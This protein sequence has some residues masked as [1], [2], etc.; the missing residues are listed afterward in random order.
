VSANRG[1]DL[2]G[3]LQDAWARTLRAL[4]A[5]LDGDFELAQHVLDDLS[6]DL[7]RALERVER[8]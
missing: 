1:V 5:L 4:E 2:V 6:E 3:V 8:P 7:W